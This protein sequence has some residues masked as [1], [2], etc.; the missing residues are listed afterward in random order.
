MHEETQELVD[1]ATVQRIY[2]QLSWMD[3]ELDPDPLLLGPKRL[4]LKVAEVRTHLSTCERFFQDVSRAHHVVR[5]SW[6]VSKAE[7]DIRTIDLMAN[8]PEVQAGRS[9]ADRQAL[10]TVKL[11]EQFKRVKNLEGAIQ[12]L[13]DLLLVIKSKRTDLNGILRALRDQIKLCQEEIALGDKWGARPFPV[14]QPMRKTGIDSLL[15]LNEGEEGKK[16]TLGWDKAQPTG[17]VVKKTI[18]DTSSE[19]EVDDFLGYLE[20]DEISLTDP[21]EEEEVERD[22]GLEDFLK[23]F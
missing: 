9:V 4:N 12:E 3:V 5:R 22:E 21:E 20:V 18:G 8:D 6:T 13:E 1:K 23:E 11:M 14:S 16:E 10:T 7:Y 17:G 15:S 2:E 19:E